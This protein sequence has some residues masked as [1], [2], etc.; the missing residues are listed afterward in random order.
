MIGFL[1]AS[2]A[3]AQEASD[4]AEADRKMAARD[5]AGALAAYDKVIEGARGGRARPRRARSAVAVAL[6]PNAP[7]D[8]SRAA[9]S[10]AA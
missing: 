5:F 9:T 6:A 3:W 2:A 1:L 4:L 8:H 7:S 10:R